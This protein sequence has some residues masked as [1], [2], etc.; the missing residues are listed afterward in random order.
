MLI[1]AGGGAASRWIMT[2][3][4]AERGW[5]SSGEWR[6]VAGSA[7]A[8]LAFWGGTSRQIA[9]PLARRVQ[10]PRPVRFVDEIAG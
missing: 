4:S 7:E 8:P 6:H 1:L 10:M 3:S 2:S 9:E 5:D